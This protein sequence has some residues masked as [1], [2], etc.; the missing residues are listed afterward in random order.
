MVNLTLFGGARMGGVN[1]RNATAFLDVH[2]RYAVDPGVPSKAVFLDPAIDGTVIASPT[3][4]ADLTQSK[5]RTKALRYEKPVR[6]DDG[7][8]VQGLQ[9]SAQVS[10]QRC[11]PLQ[12]GADGHH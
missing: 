10:L 6:L 8:E 5:S 7:Q 9:E 2:A 12:I 3:D 4:R 1:T 11:Q